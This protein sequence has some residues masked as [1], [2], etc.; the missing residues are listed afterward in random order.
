M[1][2]IFYLIKIDL[3]KLILKISSKL[4][5]KNNNVNIKKKFQKNYF[6]FY[7]ENKINVTIYKVNHKKY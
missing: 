1:K 7:K 2:L 3:K 4:K 6:I 5:E